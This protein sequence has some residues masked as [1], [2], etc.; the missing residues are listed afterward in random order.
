VRRAKAEKSS[1]DQVIQGRQSH[2]Q[3]V[4]QG[5]DRVMNDVQGVA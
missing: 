5:N 3:I 4:E 2:C 1:R